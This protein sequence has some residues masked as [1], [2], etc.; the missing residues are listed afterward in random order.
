MKRYILLLLLLSGT[1]T[2]AAPEGCDFVNDPNPSAECVSWFKAYLAANHVD[3]PKPGDANYFGG[4]PEPTPNP[5]PTSLVGDE[6][7]KLEARV[8]NF[9]QRLRKIERKLRAVK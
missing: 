1:A 9:G 7:N 5:A 3:E 2:A 6:L 4:I 8:E